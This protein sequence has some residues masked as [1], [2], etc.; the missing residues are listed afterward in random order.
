[1]QYLFNIN[2]SCNMHY[3][4][5]FTY[6]TLILHLLLNYLLRQQFCRPRLHESSNMHP[7]FLIKTLVYARTLQSR[8]PPSLITN[9][10]ILRGLRVTATNFFKRHL[11]LFPLY[12]VKHIR[13]SYWTKTACRTR[14]STQ[15]SVTGKNQGRIFAK[16]RHEL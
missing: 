15:A 5:I 7:D 9:M 12:Y 14:P 6:V 8:Q 13:R 10:K 11:N 16:S 3:D 2:L 4:T 1:M